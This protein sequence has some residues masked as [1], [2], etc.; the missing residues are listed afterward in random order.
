MAE[1]K[2]IWRAAIHTVEHKIGLYSWSPG[3]KKCKDY[4]KYGSTVRTYKRV[5][6]HVATGVSGG[7]NEIHCDMTPDMRNNG[8]RRD[9]RY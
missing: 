3:E 5:L 7:Y 8:A 1:C 9:G 6:K 2:T 4:A